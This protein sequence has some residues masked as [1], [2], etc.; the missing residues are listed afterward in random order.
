LAAKHARYANTER[1]PGH[2][3]GFFACFEYFAVGLVSPSSGS[4][5]TEITPGRPEESKTLEVFSSI[6]F[7]QTKSKLV[8]V[9]K[10][11]K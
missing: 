11:N 10:K 1:F 8:K 3:P 7:G 6:G 2:T 4:D 9:R 5:Q